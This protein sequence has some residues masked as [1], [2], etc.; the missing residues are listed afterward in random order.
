MSLVYSSSFNNRDAE[1]MSITH[2]FVS[3]YQLNA[4]FRYYIKQ[5]IYY[6]R[7]L[8]M[9]RTVLCSSSEE[10]VVLLQHLVLS[11]SVNGRTVRRLRADSVRSQPAYCT[12]VYRE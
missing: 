6:I 1:A 9:F 12:A 10:Q 3:N 11:L 2:K 4:Q 7:I 8:D 5:F